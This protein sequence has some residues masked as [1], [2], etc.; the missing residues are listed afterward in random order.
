MKGKQRRWENERKVYEGQQ[1]VS[2]ND[3]WLY[4]H[5]GHSMGGYAQKTERKNVIHVHT[6]ECYGEPDEKRP[7]PR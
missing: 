3:H 7:R 2:D 4:R 1:G 6:E 5:V